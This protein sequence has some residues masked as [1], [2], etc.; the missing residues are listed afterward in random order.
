GH[1]ATL[2]HVPAVE[3]RGRRPRRI[4]LEVLPARRPRLLAHDA[5][6]LGADRDRLGRRDA[7]R[8]DRRLQLVLVLP[9]RDRGVARY[10]DVE[11]VIPGRDRPLAEHVRILE[12]HVPARRLGPAEEPER[13]RTAAREDHYRPGTAP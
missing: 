7:P 2:R 5:L 10:P 9:A 11:D 3:E 1:G 6:T 8:R 13:M 12:V 4:R